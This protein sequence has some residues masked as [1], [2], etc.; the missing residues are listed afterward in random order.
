MPTVCACV[1][2]PRDLEIPVFFL[3][4]CNA[5][6]ALLKEFMEEAEKTSNKVRD[7]SIEILCSLVSTILQLA[8]RISL[9]P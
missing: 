7:N 1:K 9:L 4:V 2:N 5:E 8:M 6:P 3:D